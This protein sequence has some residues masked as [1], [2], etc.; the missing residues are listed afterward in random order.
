MGMSDEA[1]SILQKDIDCDENYVSGFSRATSSVLAPGY[2]VDTISREAVEVVTEAMD[3]LAAHVQTSKDGQEII[4][5][6]AWT[7][8]EMLMATTDAVYGPGNPYKDKVLEK[9]WN[10]FERSYLTLGLSPFKAFLAP[11]ALR[12]RELIAAAWTK[13]IQQGLHQQAS[14]FAKAMHAYDRSHGLQTEDLART[15]IGHS[16]AML[17]STAPAAWWM[18]YHIFSDPMVLADVREELEAL[19]GRGGLGGENGSD[20]VE[21]W[22]IDMANIRTKCPILLSVFKETLRH[23]S[24]G[25]QVR[26][27]LEDQLIDNYLLKKGGIVIIPQNVQHTS[28]EAWGA[29]AHIFDHLRFVDSKTKSGF[30]KINHTAFRAFGGGH[31]MCPGR[32]LSST[33]IMAFAALMVLRFDVNPVDSGNGIA[34]WKEPTWNNTPAVATFPV[35]DVAFRVSVRPRDNKKW[36]LRFETEVSEGRPGMLITAEDCRGR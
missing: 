16:F 11:T 13:Y 29:D 19:A 34:R 30:R 23:R 35:P 5:L 32:H 24:L 25:V 12:N 21:T 26:L 22:T 9:A 15:E 14:E 4:D 33:Q 20:D 2:A 1:G 28:E 8:R 10:E 36:I 31:T 7:H 27:C 6:W 18:M 17:G 3:N